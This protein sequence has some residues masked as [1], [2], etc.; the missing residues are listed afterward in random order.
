MAEEKPVNCHK[1]SQKNT[2]IIHGWTR[3]L[4]IGR[5]DLNAK[6]AKIAK[7]D[8]KVRYKEW[9]FRRAERGRFH[10][11]AS[12]TQFFRSVFPAVKLI[13]VFR[14]PALVQFF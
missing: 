11:V 10:C 4:P 3:L 13:S 1:R 8:A 14:R 2:E 7:D 9:E 6:S 12:C 5:G